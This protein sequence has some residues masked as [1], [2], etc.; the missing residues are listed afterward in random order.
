MKIVFRIIN[1]LYDPPQPFLSESSN[2]PHAIF[3]FDKIYLCIH[4]TYSQPGDQ[5]PKTKITLN[6]ADRM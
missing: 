4:I 6:A 1:N 3:T 5:S 2:L